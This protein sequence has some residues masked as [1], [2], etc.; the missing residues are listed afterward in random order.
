MRGSPR[1]LPGDEGE[2]VA[3]REETVAEQTKTGTVKKV[4][5]DGGHLVVAAARELTFTVTNHTEITEGGQARKLADIKAAGQVTVTYVKEG[6]TRAARRIEILPG[7]LP[8]S[9]TT[10][11]T[12]PAPGPDD[13]QITLQVG[14]LTRTCLLHLPPGHSDGRLL[15]L[16]IAFHGSGGSGSG[17]AGMTGFS[18]LADKHGFIAAYPNGII[19]KGL[20]NTL[21]GQVP[22]G[23]GVLA[24]DVDDVAFIRELIDSWIFI[25]TSFTVR[26]KRER[27]DGHASITHRVPPSTQPAAVRWLSGET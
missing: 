9:P 19:G 3:P 8:A 12:A 26:H 24:D 25:S 14:T 23:V 5:M 16:V 22:G 10:K 13:S 20:W 1:R 7:K 27:A 17:M 18:L 4:D 21:F 15:P 2:A 11:A 6:D